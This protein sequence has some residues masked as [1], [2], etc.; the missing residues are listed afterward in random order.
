MALYQRQAY[1][2]W[3]Y[4]FLVAGKRHR[5]STRTADRA[6]AVA[7]EARVRSELEHAAAQ[8]EADA[9]E[10]IQLKRVWDV[11]QSWLS[12][13]EATL[14]DHKG[15]VSRVRKLF[16]REMRLFG[17]T[18]ME[19]ASGRYGLPRTMTIREVTPEVLG[20]LR[21]AR[22]RE[23]QSPQTIDREVSLIRMLIAHAHTC[24]A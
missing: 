11:S 20:A 1:G 21:T 10:T 5:A 7:I 14:R 13:S 16:G 12:L 22:T 17:E 8:R 15:N 3:Y 18:W 19:I 2:V 4:E 24:T 6:E 23:G 9:A